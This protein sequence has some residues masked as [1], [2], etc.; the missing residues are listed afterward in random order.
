MKKILPRAGLFLVFLFV[1]LSVFWWRTM[2]WTGQ[3][4]GVRAHFDGQCTSAAKIVGAED[5]VIDREMRLVYI[6]S[7]DRRNPASAGSIWVMP[8]DA[9]ET[10]KPLA[11]PDLGGALF[12]PHGM[13]LLITED[14]SRFLFMID[15]GSAP[16]QLVRLFKVTGESLELVR[17]FESPA[18]YSPN[19]IAA[20]SETQ[21]YLTNDNREKLGSLDA[22]LA[23]L[24][25][26]RTG[27]VVWMDDGEAKAVADG[28]SYANGIATSNDLNQL[29]VSST[30]TQDLR[31]FDRDTATG[32]LTLIDSIFLSSGLDNVDVAED[33]S[34]WIGSHPRLFDFS[35]HAKDAAKDSPS[36]VFRLNPKDKSISE[37]F[38]SD[39]A[40]LSA[41]SVA[42]QIDNLIFMGGVFD[43]QVLV[44]EQ[45]SQPDAET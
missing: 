2:L 37:V 28:F 6:S 5:L 26:R 1:V 20:V 24:F 40:D 8:V 10:A 3:L 15:H 29:Y 38:V 42:A 25:K 14:G 27:N 16:K 36:Q 34:L 19:D 35:A 30:I 21:F 7:H 33:G 12:A 22:F 13:D 18:F 4:R 44:C 32:E 17:T 45:K 41:L 43:T 11:L 39:G 31:I 23:V 9:P